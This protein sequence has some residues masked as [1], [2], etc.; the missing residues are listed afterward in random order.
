MILSMEI[1]E[2]CISSQCIQS[3]WHKDILFQAS[4]KH[5]Q[6]QPW[7]LLIDHP[8]SLFNTE[9]EFKSASLTQLGV[10]SVSWNINKTF[11]EK[12]LFL[13]SVFCLGELF[14]FSAF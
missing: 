9:S 6:D 14:Y 13:N 4:L 11:F 10:I 1:Y 8:P 5:L 7:P 2:N 3:L 12:F